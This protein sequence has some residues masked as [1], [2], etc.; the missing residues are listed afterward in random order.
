MGERTN[1]LVGT[2]AAVSRKLPRP[3]AVII[4]SA[5]AAG[6]T[7]LMDAVLAFVPPEERVHYAAMTGQALYYLGETDLRHKVLSVVEEEGAT[8]SWRIEL[9]PV[10]WTRG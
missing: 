2:P 8:A 7:S 10:P 5:S 4:Q 3:L 1:L 9:L 6:K